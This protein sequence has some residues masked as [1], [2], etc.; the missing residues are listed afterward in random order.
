MK[1]LFTEN[2]LTKEGSDILENAGYEVAASLC[3][4]REI[5]YLKLSCPRFESA[6]SQRSDSQYEPVSVFL[7][8][9]FPANQ[10]QLFSE[11]RLV[12]P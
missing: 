11:C 2:Y 8:H 4:L 10:Y 6:P 7:V 12:Y 9:H 5:F 1:V 3:G